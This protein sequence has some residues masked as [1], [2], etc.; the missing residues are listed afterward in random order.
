[1][2]VLTVVVLLVLTL[3][4]MPAHTAHHG[5]ADPGSMAALAGRAGLFVAA[6]A[7]VGVALATIARGTLGALAVAAGY[8]FLVE[9]PVAP[10][11]PGL[12]HWLPIAVAA[13][14][15]SADGSHSPLAAGAVLI[16]LALALLATAD[17]LFHRQD[18]P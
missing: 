7:V 4:L 16:A 10:F 17:T 8:A 14:W 12:S 15:V 3:T 2:A 18:I 13:T 1:M 11:W 6:A 9:Q 5:N